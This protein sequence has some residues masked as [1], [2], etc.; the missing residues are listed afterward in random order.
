M[1]DVAVGPLDLAARVDDALAVQALAFGLSD[2][3]IAVRR[4]IVRT[5]INVEI[6]L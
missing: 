4:H 2:D 6:K 5:R 3:E 1:D